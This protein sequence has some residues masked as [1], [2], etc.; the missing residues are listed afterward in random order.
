MMKLNPKC[1]FIS[2]L[3][4]IFVNFYPVYFLLPILEEGMLLVNDIVCDYI[5]VE[6]IKS[7]QCVT[8]L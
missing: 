6:T 8:E 3:K 1:S 2:K 4:F 7:V 5:T